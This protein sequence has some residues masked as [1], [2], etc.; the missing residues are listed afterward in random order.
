VNRAPVRRQREPRLSRVDAIGDAHVSHADDDDA[1]A[2]ADQHG[3]GEQGRHSPKLLPIHGLGLSRNGVLSNFDG[4]SRAYV[5]KIQPLAE[6]LEGGLTK[7]LGGGDTPP[8]RPT[9]TSRR[10][11]REAPHPFSL[12]KWYLLT[13]SKIIL[14]CWR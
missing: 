8:L 14:L 1:G 5:I 7:I 13:L 12:E 9:M 6:Y 10:P 4:F 2:A 11:L 3:G